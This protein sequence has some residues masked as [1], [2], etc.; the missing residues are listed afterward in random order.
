ME[1]D[2]STKEFI[3]GAI[4]FSIILGIF[5]LSASKNTPRMDNGT[6]IYEIRDYYSS[7]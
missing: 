6:P 4:I 7:P 3:I 1:I 5:Y 2:E